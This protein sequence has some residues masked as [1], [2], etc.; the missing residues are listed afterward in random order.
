MT[1]TTPVANPVATFRELGVSPAA[2]TALEARGYERPL[3]VQAMVLPDILEGRDI[4]AKSP[5]GSGKTLAFMVPLLDCLDANKAGRPSALILAPTRELA[6]QIVEESREVAHALA[7]RVCAVYGGVGIQRQ[8]RDAARAHVIVATPG[9]LEDL[10]ARGA[11]KL[12]QIEILVLDEADRMLDMG[13]KPPID[14]IVAQVPGDR[15]TLFFSATLDGEAGRIAQAYTVDAARHEHAPPTRPITE[16]DHRFIDTRGGDKV[17]VLLDILE[18]EERGLAI[19]FVR[20]KHG[21]DRLSKR[22][23]QEGVNSGAMHGG[24]TQGQRERALSA[25]ERGKIDVLVATDVAA[26]GIDIDDITHVINYDIPEDRETYVH[27][28]GRTGR[29]GRTG[30][31]M[32]LVAPDQVGDMAEIA[33][34]LGLADRYEAA[35][36][37]PNARAGGKK[38]RGGGGNRGGGGGQRQG[39]GG[40]RDFGHGGGQSGP[41]GESRGHRSGRS[42]GESQGGG[43]RPRGRFEDRGP[44]EDRGGFGDR[45]PRSGGPRSDDRSSRSGGG[46]YEERA[47]RS[48]GPRGDDRGPR[49]GSGERSYGGRNDGWAQRP[50]GGRRD[51]AQRSR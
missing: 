32:T 15:Q 47:P 10:L 17:N 33:R 6:S 13:F 28:I 8:A 34:D 43:D 50:A 23:D 2:S 44:R 49:H 7:L 19:V 18:N 22:L 35:G 29:A 16:M 39:G 5:T 20:T 14:R 45:G 30:I 26:R 31:G 36:L 48:G 51:G 38:K 42:H 3:P 1:S 12:D 21:A 11:F 37:D 46:R 41:R 40:W 4:L 25:F 24:K 9:R 27:R